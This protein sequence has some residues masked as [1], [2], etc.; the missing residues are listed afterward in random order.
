MNTKLK[1]IKLKNIKIIKKPIKIIIN[2]KPIKMININNSKKNIEIITG[3]NPIKMIN[4]N[5]PKKN[6]NIL[7]SNKN[8]NMSK[9]IF[10]HNI[11]NY[12]VIDENNSIFLKINDFIDNNTY[13]I[14]FDTNI[15]IYNEDTILLIN[16]INYYL[17]NG[18]KIL[19]LIDQKSIK[20][21]V[22]YDFENI[23]K[24]K[25]IKDIDI[26]VFLDIYGQNL[27]KIFI[28]DIN[29]YDK[30]KN[31][32]YKDKIVFYKEN[33][34]YESYQ[35][36]FTRINDYEQNNDIIKLIYWIDVDVK[37]NTI[38]IIDIFKKLN[39]EN[40]NTKL[41]IY[42]LNKILD[43]KHLDNINEKIKD[44]KNI[45][46]FKDNI[47]YIDMKYELQI[48]K[49]NILIFLQND[50]DIDFRSNNKYKFLDILTS[51]I[52]II[53]DIR[54]YV[55]V[56]V[57]NNNENR[58]DNIIQNFKEQIYFNKKLFIISDNNKIENKLIENNINYEIIQKKNNDEDYNLNLVIDILKKKN[59]E[60]ISKFNENNI[61]EQYY[62]L[63]QIKSLYENDCNIVCKT[64]ELFFDINDL[65]FYMSKENNIN[66]YVDFCHNDSLTYNINNI[67]NLYS[68]NTNNNIAKNF[69]KEIIENGG[70]IYST[71]SENFINFDLYEKDKLEKIKLNNINGR[72]YNL[73]FDNIFII[74]LENY[75]TRKMYC[76]KNNKHTNIKFT[77]FKGVDG[78]NDKE[79][80]KIFNEYCK[81]ELCY[82]GCSNLEKKYKRKMINYVGQI[83][84]LKSM[85]NVL[86]YSKLKK[87]KKIIIFDDDV[88][89][90][91]NFN[92][93]F[94][95]KL[96]HINNNYDILRI[97]T[98][99]H[100]YSKCKDLIKQPVYN[101]IDTDGSFA[102]C[103]D[104]NCFNFLLENIK[105]YNIPFDS[106]CLR[107]YKKNDYTCYE[108]LAI[109]DLYESSITNNPRNLYDTSIKLGWNIENF[110]IRD[111][112]RKISI[113]FPIYN[114]EKTVINSIRSILAQTYTNIELILVNDCS[115]DN[116]ENII[117]NFLKKYDG[118]IDIKYYKHYKNKGCYGS[119][120]TAIKNSSGRFIAIQDPDDYSLPYRLELQ[121][122]DIITKNIKISY[123]GLYRMNHIEIKDIDNLLLLKYKDCMHNNTKTWNYRV[124]LGINTSLTDK[125][126][127]DEYGLYD[128]YFK[129]SMDLWYIQMVYMYK[130]KYDLNNLINK[131][132]NDKR[133]FFYLY[134]DKNLDPHNFIYYNNTLVL[135]SEIMD[136]N[137][138][139]N[140]YK[141][142]KKNNDYEIFKKKLKN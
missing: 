68:N 104:S 61:Y 85:L 25:F 13:L 122:N 63:E 59:I 90:H 89:L 124:K 19:I 133:G 38:N 88:I 123:A 131:V 102:T 134:I 98:T 39:K 1:N 106:G 117:L 142:E 113:I 44:K 128:E 100:N 91:K 80:I 108:Y 31:T 129:H 16:I 2:K 29:S 92:N 7:S 46:E 114:K 36:S 86:E 75:K 121:I 64:N 15:N 28:R 139:T 23:N 71:S 20:K 47:N 58:L 96:Q 27:N 127:F 77:I 12:D 109:A 138:I 8:H 112:L 50:L 132:N 18:N 3:K 43:K 82:D 84:Y 10:N 48:N 140:F 4:I 60:I 55:G 65:N 67:F 135:I 56:V 141:E 40:K 126:I 76:L 136:E 93:L 66:K 5:N 87:Y 125:S 120:N 32:I 24:L 62:L 54:K 116:T 73:I 52:K 49:N 21:S 97:G 11:N 101:T 110:Y 69:I 35:Y 34:P 33:F 95:E 94:M 30:I 37:D 74:N 17:K 53:Y 70:K 42:T 45:I 99:F 22:L 137:N 111:S 26:I 115:T 72:I 81:K 118:T 107:D 130:F 78:K 51:K 103:L 57:F 41:Y 83:G 9:F 79:S 14:Y 6:N 105:K 119:R